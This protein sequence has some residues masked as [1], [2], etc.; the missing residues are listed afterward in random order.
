VA[1]HLGNEEVGDSGGAQAT[2]VGM[3]ETVEHEFRELCIFEGLFPTPANVIQRLI[4]GAHLGEYKWGEFWSEHI[5]P[6][7]EFG[8]WRVGRL[9]IL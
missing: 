2:R 9:D 5:A 3:P 4:C 8:E 7:Q 1:D 6:A